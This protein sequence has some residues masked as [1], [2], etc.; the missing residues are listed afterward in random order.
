MMRLL[1]RISIPYLLVLISL[2]SP[3]TARAV[4]GVSYTLIPTYTWFQWDDE[5]GLE[6]TELWGGRLGYNFGR[7]VSLEGYYLGRDDVVTRLGATPI[8]DIPDLDFIEQKVDL[9][10]YGADLVLNLGTSGVTPFLRGGGG[11]L[12]MNPRVGDD[13]KVIAI[14]G[15]G[16]FRFGLDRFQIEVFAEDTAFRLD[17]LDLVH[18]AIPVGAVDPGSDDVRHN[19]TFGAGVNL[20]LGGSSGSGTSETD[21]AVAERFRSGL[22]G[23]S[24]PI[25]P[26]VGRLE[27]N[28]QLG[29][30]RQDVLG[31]RSGL[32]LGP[33]VGLR[34]HYWRGMN[35]A[36]DDDDPIQSWGAEAQFNLS[37]GEGAIP[38]L[39]GGVG[40]LDFEPEYRDR[41]GQ[42]R[43]DRTMLIVGGGLAFTLGDRFRAHAFARDHVM[44]GENLED[45]STTSDLF[46]SWMIGAGFTFNLFGS[47]PDGRRG[48]LSPAPPVA[49]AAP[50]VEPDSTTGQLPRDPTAA[51]SPATE[52]AAEAADEPPA[53]MTEIER[54]YAGERT[55]TIPV[56]TEGEIYIRY[57]KPGAV[58]IESRS[59]DAEAL[60]SPETSQ[61]PTSIPEG[62]ALD[63]EALRAVIRDE[64]TRAVAAPRSEVVTAGDLAAMERRLSDRIDERVDRGLA[65]TRSDGGTTVIAVEPGGE[66]GEPYGWK[67][68]SA[69][70]YIGFSLDDPEQF[71][72]GSRLTL[73]PVTRGS[74]VLFE[75]EVAL[76][77]GGG[78]TSFLIAGNLTLPFMAIEK[79]G[80]WSPFVSLGAG[81]LRFSGDGEADTDL[82]I[83]AGYGA[84]ARL[85]EWTVFAEHQGI[86]VFDL[87]RILLGVRLGK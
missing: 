55:V 14:K 20:K 37:T 76:G 19:L 77:T 42:P 86:K 30:G 25:E 44:S 21:A 67:L 81:F 66:V 46:S 64:L 72:A 65:A 1:H 84:S 52:A 43:E 57:G 40:Q 80:D 17:R 63:I 3:V 73:G 85:G 24:I 68:R 79:R 4:E 82:V 49:A 23:L 29:L 10:H 51:D 56:P 31:F 22:A 5:L 47:S 33:Y 59:G 69:R 39:V 13:V 58:A 54:S 9:R 45:V 87:N 34:G 28:D 27:F 32:D 74:R 7:H 60:E 38:Y 12:Q 35:D 6:D 48:F 83:N 8:A 41:R 71:V 61:A 11:V 78:V 18:G 75:P 50:A 53:P 16:G 2:L 36:F 15:G 62:G 26:F 70:P